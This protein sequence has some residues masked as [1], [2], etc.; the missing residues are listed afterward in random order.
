MVKVGRDFSMLELSNVVTAA[1]AIAESDI[2]SAKI[3]TNGNWALLGNFGFLSSIYPCD[4]ACGER[5]IYP[6]FP[7]W[8]GKYSTQRK[9]QRELREFRVA[10][11]KSISGSR[12]AVKFDY[13]PVLLSR[14][15]RLLKKQTDE[16][17]EKV[18]DLMESYGINP[19]HIKEHMNDLMYPK[20]D[21]YSEVP[22]LVKAK[23]T[24]S[25]NKRFNDDSTNIKGEN[26]RPKGVKKDVEPK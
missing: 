21:Y 1:A 5:P 11:A 26:A 22:P 7:E 25:Y 19:S 8:L 17:V 2:L 18:L 4:K 13:V 10:I 3:R 12:F 14:I 9:T 16:S 23:L 6:R 15:I 20:K 24:R